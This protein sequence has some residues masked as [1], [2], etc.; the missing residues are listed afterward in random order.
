MLTA[1]AG[2][3]PLA[4]EAGKLAGR[5]KDRVAV[6]TGGA[7]GIGRAS[8]ELF[9]AEGACVL[10]VDLRPG[11]PFAV[12]AVELFAIDISQSDAPAAIV[13]EAE[14]RFGGLDIVFNNA[15][16]SQ[17]TPLMEMSDADWDRILDVNLRAVFRLTRAASPLLVKSHA[18][19][20]IATASTAAK[21]SAGHMGAYDVSKA[22]VA[23]L[24]RAFAADLGPHGV[25]ANAILPGPTKTPMVAAR[26]NDAARVEAWTKHTFLKRL[27]EPEEIARVAL[28][29]A[30][31]DSSN[32][33]GQAIAADG[34]F[35]SSL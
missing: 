31:D 7:S 5:L 18:G 29:L 15:G 32:V 17:V 20:V 33:T 11:E 34:G 24:M 8:A 12:K 4:T 13:A 27:A 9:A 21:L 25:T 16:V 30:S 35:A 2:A 22:G 23:V 26:L 10:A 1:A 19:R 3:G 14:R 28:F 6:V